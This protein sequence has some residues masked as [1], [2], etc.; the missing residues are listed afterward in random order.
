[1]VAGPTNP[2]DLPPVLTLVVAT[3]ISPHKSMVSIPLTGINDISDIY[4]SFSPCIYGSYLSRQCC[5]WI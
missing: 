3:H 4:I 5:S 2:L 1:M